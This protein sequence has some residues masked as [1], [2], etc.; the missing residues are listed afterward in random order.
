MDNTNGK[1]FARRKTFFALRCACRATESPAVF[2]SLDSVT[3]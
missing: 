2:A 3:A 1:A